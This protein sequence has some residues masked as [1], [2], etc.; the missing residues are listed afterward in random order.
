MTL[1][2]LIDDIRTIGVN[3]KM[4]K[5]VYNGPV[6]NVMDERELIYPVM[7]FD[8]VT[9]RLNAQSMTY[10]FQFF[11]FDRL[12]QGSENE[13]E[14]QSDQV[15]IAKDIVAQLRFPGFAWT[16]SDPVAVNLF[17]DSTPE[18]LAGCQLTVTIDLPNAADRCQVP[19]DYTYPTS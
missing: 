7:T 11:F 19:T 4:I 12:Q 17:T 14:V 15:E 6:M 13:R 9:A 8:T 16:V 2:E 3:H 1:N 10:D 5:T 18:L